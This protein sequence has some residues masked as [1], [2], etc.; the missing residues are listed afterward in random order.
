MVLVG[1]LLLFVE[2]ISFGAIYSLSGSQGIQP[3]LTEFSNAQGKIQV[4]AF[5]ITDSRVIDSLI[6]AGKKGV[7]IE[8][9]IDAAQANGNKYSLH[10]RLL[11]AKIKG[12]QVKM[13]S[14]Q[15]INVYGIV[16]NNV[17]LIGP[18]QLFTDMNANPKQGVFEI[19]RDNDV[20]SMI[21]GELQAVSR[22]SK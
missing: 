16:D 17:A 20:V 21:R 9:I 1:F 12:M 2:G 22:S 10:Q 15:V 4:Y 18:Q 8:V 19:S 6:A 3:I 7:Q 14:S 11:D 5:V 13:T